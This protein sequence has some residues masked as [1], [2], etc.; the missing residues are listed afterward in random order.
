MTVNTEYTHDLTNNWKGAFLE[1]GS[2]E[3]Y[4]DT[5]NQHM[6]MPLASVNRLRA[7]FKNLKVEA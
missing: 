6:V 7:I 2:F 4:N 5:L 3:V 1:D